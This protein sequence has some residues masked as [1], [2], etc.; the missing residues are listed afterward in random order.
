MFR[1]DY[2]I[3]LGIPRDESAAGIHS[4]YRDLAKRHHPDVAGPSSAGRFWHRF[5]LT[6]ISCTA[7]GTVG[8][9]EGGQALAVVVKEAS[10]REVRLGWI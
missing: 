9:G 6:R 5:L 8:N 1:K 7:G 3:I 10:A 2:Y 4:A